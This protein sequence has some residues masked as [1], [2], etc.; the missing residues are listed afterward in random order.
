MDEC[1]PAYW[2]EK[3]RT[4]KLSA[5]IYAAMSQEDRKHLAN[6]LAEFNANSPA[7]ARAWKK[8]IR[9]Q[10]EHDKTRNHH[11]K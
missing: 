9:P 11:G 3:L 6:R 10:A 2:H 1:S 7:G 5:D 4:S 8:M